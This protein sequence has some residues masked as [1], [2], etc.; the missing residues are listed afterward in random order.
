MIKKYLLVVFLCLSGLVKSQESIVLPYDIPYQNALKFNRFLMNPTFSFVG[1]DRSYINF[2]HRNQWMQ[3]DDSPKTY[4]VN[5]SGKINER[6]GV[7][8]GLYQQRVGIF[9]NFGAIA[10][11]AYNV[12]FSD[13]NSLTF[14]FNFVYYNSGID[15]GRAEPEEPDPS[16]QQVGNDS[17]IALHP[18]INLTLGSFD[19]G[20]YAENLVNYNITKGEFL[21]EFSGKTF[22]GH[23]MYT[24]KVENG[25][26]LFEEGKVSVIARGRSK[27]NEDFNMSAGGILDLPKVGWVQ[28]GYD[29]FYG[30]SY[31][32]GFHL[33]Q[34]LSLGYTY[35]KGIKDIITNFGGTHEI[36]FAYSFKP[37]TQERKNW[38]PK[39]R[40]ER[41][42]QEETIT[43]P[44]LEEPVEEP[45]I[46]IEEELPLVFP[47]EEL[48][49]TP[50]TDT[51]SI[52]LEDVYKEYS[53]TNQEPSKNRVLR[54]N[55]EGVEAGYYMIVNVY[56]KD[57]N[58]FRFM[59]ELHAKGFTTTS[60]FTDQKTNRRYVYLKR[61]DTLK[62]I[63]IAYKSK[64]NNY[65]DG[66]KWILQVNK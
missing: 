46:K 41:K 65:Y 29:D 47:K 32:L 59:E 58:L 37:R 39:E 42:V 21:K 54:Q 45:K 10:N 8:L 52:S 26:G 20:L 1:E 55:F 22:A 51:V 57:E 5:Y 19:I 4:F 44:I 25:E 6:A 31:G 27:E 33:S 50:E 17:F 64:L 9:T 16:I 14:G 61:Y 63:T 2:Y 24:K 30:M 7:G 35:E 62:E 36:V 3:F 38:E 34:R 28:V 60:Y 53:R 43:K 48:N 23:L 13:K 18:G 15:P 40:K 11:Y 56:E 66:P 12:K 49:S